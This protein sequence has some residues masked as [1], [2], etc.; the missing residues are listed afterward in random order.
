MCREDEKKIKFFVV[1]FITTRYYK[2]NY[3]MNQNLFFVRIIFFYTSI[4][5]FFFIT[6]N[7]CVLHKKNTEYI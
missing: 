7:A 3:K 6:I 1:L 2:I 4:N 5:F